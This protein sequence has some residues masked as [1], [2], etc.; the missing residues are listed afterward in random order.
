MASVASQVE[1]CA[2]AHR[3][4]R[5]LLDTGQELIPPATEETR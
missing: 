4:R 2:F 1:H 5:N 3:D